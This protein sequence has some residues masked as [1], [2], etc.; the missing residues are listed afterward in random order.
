MAQLEEQ[1]VI[2]PETI[3]HVSGKIAVELSTRF[4]EH[5][6]EQL[7]SSPQK[8]FEEL[9]SNG[10]DAGASRVDVR[11]SPD[12]TAGNATMSVLDNGASMDAEGLRQL[13]HIAFSPKKD[14]GKV[15]DWQACDL[16]I[17]VKFN[18]HLQSS[19]REDSSCHDGLRPN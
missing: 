9:I 10:W 12:L 15:W 1:S 17:S 8:A 11:V 3:G 7:Y 14:K 6:S 5:F 4:L 19:R 2:S 13:W 18:L 16:R